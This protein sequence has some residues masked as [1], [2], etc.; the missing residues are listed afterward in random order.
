MPSF[1]IHNDTSVRMKA[2]ESRLLIPTM[3]T[4]RW[5]LHYYTSEARR[6]FVLFGYVQI[7]QNWKQRT[8]Q[9]VKV[10]Y[11]CRRQSV[12]ALT[13]AWTSSWTKAY[14]RASRRA[15]TTP[16]RK[17]S[18]ISIPVIFKNVCTLVFRT[19]SVNVTKIALFRPWTDH[20]S[21]RH[22]AERFVRRFTSSRRTRIRTRCRRSLVEARWKWS[23]YN[24]PFH[25]CFA[26]IERNASRSAMGKSNPSKMSLVDKRSRR[27]L[28]RHGL[29]VTAIQMAMTMGIIV[30]RTLFF[31]RVS[32]YTTMVTILVLT[33]YISS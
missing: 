7:V 10:S 30:T 23:Y 25:F 18:T 13:P 11:S 20:A 15:T 6:V 16:W 22:I 32:Q 5:W 31:V 3:T 24:W 21:F 12:A 4:K 28:R 14:L 9:Y 33:Q 2:S 29:L 26:R 1:A 17:S 8:A 27:L 19:C